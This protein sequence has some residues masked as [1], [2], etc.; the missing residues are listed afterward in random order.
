MTKK[1]AL[2]RLGKVPYGQALAFQFQ[3]RERLKNREDDEFIGY[4]LALE[5]PPTVTLGKRGSFDDLVN[6]AWLADKG[7]EVYR[8]D[9]GGE[10]TYHE[11]GQLVVY[12]VIR[13]KALGMG[14]VDVIRGM[15]NCLA[16]TCSPYGVEAAYDLD[17]PGLWTTHEEP[18]RKIASVGM[19]VQ[20]GVTTHGAAMNLV[21][22]MIGFSMIV[23]CG[24]P[25]A[26]MARLT[27]Y[28]AEGCDFAE[29]REAFL[30]NFA[31]FLGVELVA[32]EM[33][34]PAEDEW[35][36]PTRDWL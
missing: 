26:P 34:M 25:N 10:A 27:D 19:R 13:L 28:C 6:H 33:E 29:F 30:Q 32:H 5:H 24:M 14:V 9:R 22:E 31:D 17:H 21:N 16:Q 3:L 8:I 18:S 7:V 12:P 11:P 20:S 23:P 36:K 4:V 1:L 35:V 15:A 2:L